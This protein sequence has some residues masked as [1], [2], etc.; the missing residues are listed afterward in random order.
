MRVGEKAGDKDEDED[1]EDE[2]SNLRRETVDKS[3]DV[4]FC[5]RLISPDCL[6]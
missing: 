1:G 2:K 5:D 3:S 4:S 6:V